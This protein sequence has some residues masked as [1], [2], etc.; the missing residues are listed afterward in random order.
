[1]ETDACSETLSFLMYIRWWINSRNSVTVSYNPLKMKASS[2]ILEHSNTVYLTCNVYSVLFNAIFW[3][4]LMSTTQ[5]WHPVCSPTA[6]P[7]LGEIWIKMR[8]R[9]WTAPAYLSALTSPTSLTRR[10]QSHS[11][12]SPQQNL[13]CEY[14]YTTITKTPH[15]KTPIYHFLPWGRLS[16]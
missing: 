7:H 1:M 10:P 6:S 9:A 16:L 8:Q 15:F 5:V 12:N 2:I 3:M 11:Q 4:T 14:F 13:F